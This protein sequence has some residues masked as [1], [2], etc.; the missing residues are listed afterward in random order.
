MTLQRSLFDFLNELTLNNNREW[1]TLNKSI[2]QSELSHFKIFCDELFLKMESFDLLEGKNVFRIYRDVRFSKDKQPYKTHF[3][4]GITR[5]TKWR[6]GGYYLHIQ[7]GESFIGGGFWAPEPVDLKRIRQELAAN[8]SSLEAITQSPDFKKFFGEIQGE[9][10]KTAPQSF[11]KDH[12]NI[13][14]LKFKQFL[15]IRKLNNED[16]LSGHF[17]DLVSDTFKQ[18]LPFFDYF[19]EI[20]TTDENGTPLPGY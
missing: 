17:L 15:L 11:P 20:L 16:V 12:E 19:S 7:P 14:W 13:E 3:S 10:L 4:I 9:K 18:M 8:A 5:A 1:F 2:Y 6:R